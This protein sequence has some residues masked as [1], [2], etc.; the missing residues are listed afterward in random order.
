VAKPRRSRRTLTIVVLVLLSLTII[1]VDLSGRTH[2]LTSGIKSVASDVFNPLRSGVNDI[3]RPVG[4]FFAGAVHYGSL[5][6]ENQK[7]QATV[8]QLRQAKAEQAFKNQQLQQLLAL[9]HLPYLDSLPTVT[10]KTIAISPSNFTSTITIDQGRS[11]GVDVGDPVV[12]AGGL[13]GQITESYHH[14]AVVQLINDGQSKV[15]VTFGTEQSLGTVDGQ[16]PSNPMTA[17]YIAPGTPLTKGEIMY[18]SGLNG[19]DFPSGIPVATVQS[20]HT[21]T[22]ATQI[23]VTVRAAANLNQVAYVAVVQW[24]PSA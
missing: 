1:T 24:A 20:F 4:D 7:L 11:D 15:G 21:P 12:G 19:A 10:A 14:S 16:G 5:Q 23:S 22:G 2:H 13:I 3:L 18:T 6:T 8:G 9:E 17:D